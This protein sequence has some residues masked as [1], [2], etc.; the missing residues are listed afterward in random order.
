MLDKFSGFCVFASNTFCSVVRWSANLFFSPDCLWWERV[1]YFP[2]LHPLHTFQVSTYFF[3]P[4]NI[5][6]RLAECERLVK[7]KSCSALKIWGKLLLI[8]HLISRIESS[9]TLEFRCQGSWKEFL[10]LIIKEGNSH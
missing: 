9:F 2:R 1:S 8:L 10:H 6:T 5:E 4:W 7:L 3:F